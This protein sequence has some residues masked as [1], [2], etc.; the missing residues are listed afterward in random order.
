[1]KNEQQ[2]LYK[3][4]QNFEGMQKIDVFDMLQKMEML[5]FYIS[6]PITKDSIREIMSVSFNKSQCFDTTRP[7]ILPNGNF[8]ECIGTN[9]WICIYKEQKKGIGR[10]NV[11]NTYYFK[12]KDPF[13]DIKR[14][15]K[16]DLLES[17]RD[18]A[19]EIE[20]I[21]FLRKN[22]S[23]NKEEFIKRLLLLNL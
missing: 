15:T 7:T 3:V 4:I 17:L 6:S 19:E 13:F 18:T 14:L 12:I 22:R 2:L 9:D 8:C 23:A 21:D 11:F 16:E 10:W 1:M 20:I 5:L